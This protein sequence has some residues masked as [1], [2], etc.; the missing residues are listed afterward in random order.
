M[1]R[2]VKLILAASLITN[3]SLGVFVYLRH[4]YEQSWTWSLASNAHAISAVADAYF[5]AHPEAQFVRYPDL[6][7][8]DK[9]E[10][11]KKNEQP[12]RLYQPVFCRGESEVMILFMGRYG[13][14]GVKH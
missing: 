1:S 12:E 8:W 14:L 6:K 7:A 9:T 2:F 4:V 5:L 11:I 13:T 3:L 10:W